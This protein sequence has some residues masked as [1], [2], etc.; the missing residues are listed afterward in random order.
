[1]SCKELIYGLHGR[2]HLVLEFLAGGDM[3]SFLHKRRAPLT[4]SQIRGLFYQLL[5][6]L[7]YMHS[8]QYMHRDLKPEN[9]L[10]VSSPQNEGSPLTVKIADLGL[11]KNLKQ[12][13]T[14]PPTAYIATRWYRS[15]EILL[16]LNYAYPSDMWAIAVVMVEFIGKGQPLFPGDN[17]GD[18]LT[19]IFQLC[20]HPSRVGWQQGVNALRVRGFVIASS[21]PASLRS[22]LPNASTPILQLLT[23]LLQLDPSR[24]P[25]AEQALNYPVFMPSLS[26]RM[27]D[28]R[29]RSRLTDSPG[30]LSRDSAHDEDT[31]SL[32]WSRDAQ[33]AKTTYVDDD[34]D[35]DNEFDVL[36][37]LEIVGKPEKLPDRTALRNNDVENDIDWTLPATRKLGSTERAAKR[38]HVRVGDP[39]LPFVPPGRI[40]K[41]PRLRHHQSVTRTLRSNKLRRP[42]AHFD[43][44]PQS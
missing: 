11:S 42:A 35:N 37:D 10:L 31:L 6:A 23:D 12:T 43:M 38:H 5:Q 7:R 22:V 17:Q 33:A 28:G 44:R 36:R 8:R 32:H 21:N 4:E 2:V 26:P 39:R 18:M 9:I 16:H 29:K 20:G 34:L 3:E 40:L 13:V 19:R 15:P 25:T 27:S 24:R 14:R 1:M 41:S 30:P